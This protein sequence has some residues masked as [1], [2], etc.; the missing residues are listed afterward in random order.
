MVCDTTAVLFV[1][2]SLKFYSA[3]R[4]KKLDDAWRYRLPNPPTHTAG[5]RMSAK[6]EL[7][8][9]ALRQMLVLTSW[10]IKSDVPASV[11]VSGTRMVYRF[12]RN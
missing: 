1:M 3:A 9:F 4:T 10:R 8:D 5:K 7:V 6:T 2:R 12:N 11:K